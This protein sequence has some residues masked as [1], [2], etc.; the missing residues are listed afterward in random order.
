MA[1]AV[2]PVAVVGIDHHR[3]PVAVRERLAVA[4]EAVAAVVAAIQQVCACGEVVVLS[5]CN[6]L[7]LY[8]G[9]TTDP[10]PA[11]QLL[12]ERREVDPEA[13]RAGC[14]QH[15]GVAAVQ[16]LFRVVSGIESM[17][18]G[19][20]QIVHQV[21]QAYEA[22]HAAN[23]TGAQLN[24]LF[25]RALALAKEVRTQT[26]ISRHKLSTASV[27]VD[28]AR[29]IHGD[30]SDARLLLVGAGDIAEL[31]ARYLVEA[32]VR[33]LGVVNRTAERATFLV[34]G[35][36]GRVWP[37]SGLGEA[38]AAHD[39]VV[40]STSAP[41]TVVHVADV[42]LAMRQRRA[43][44]LLID[45]AVP[46]DVEPA[47][48]ELNDVYL[49]NIDHLEAVV[50]GNRAAR[51]EEVVAATALVDRWSNGYVAEQ[52]PGQQALMTQVASFFAEVV[53]NE[54]QRLGRK[55]PRADAG[56]LRYGLER[57]GNKLQHRILKYLREHPGD[58]TA[59]RVV[60]EMLGL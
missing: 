55:L 21:K 22:G 43:P 4:P 12:A 16:H 7:E 26:G 30:L 57:V 11:L 19:E 24:P 17:V 60:R 15:T 9:G 13:L 32:G 27:A 46:R 59:E 56:E 38:L 47:V 29:Q 5:T 39:I 3:T 50:S 52:R 40:C 44:M 10:W 25:Q 34:E 14:Y 36:A 41:H 31:S 54:E 18:L 58:E 1:E 20:E 23:H 8:L 37:W 49:Y 6:R 51:S 35:T 28:L 33:H 48:A 45:L 42:R 53:A 2:L